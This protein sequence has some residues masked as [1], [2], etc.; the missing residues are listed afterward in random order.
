[1]WVGMRK[2]LCFRAGIAWI[3]IHVEHTSRWHNFDS[4]VVIYS[5]LIGQ[6]ILTRRSFRPILFATP[7]EQAMITDHDPPH[8]DGPKKADAVSRCWGGGGD[9]EFMR[10][11]GRWCAF[12][13]PDADYECSFICWESVWVRLLSFEET[14]KSDVWYACTRVKRLI[15]G[16]KREDLMEMVDPVVKGSK[17]LSS[18]YDKF[19]IMYSDNWARAATLFRFSRS[20]KCSYVCT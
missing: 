19:S 6:E 18:V 2:L 10:D 17:W 13:M 1:M 15:V 20:D 9:D 3:Y 5:I 11:I 4:T 7:M 14:Q 12:F 8:G 16:R